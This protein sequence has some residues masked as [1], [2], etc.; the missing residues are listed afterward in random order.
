M[1]PTVQFGGGRSGGKTAKQ[2]EAIKAALRA[3][4]AVA[5]GGTDGRAVELALDAAGEIIEKSRPPVDPSLWRLDAS[6]GQFVNVADPTKR[7]AAFDDELYCET[8]LPDLTRT[9]PFPPDCKTSN[10]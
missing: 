9:T 7:V 3:G 10:S 2:N 1:T 8:S 6:R 4:Q 5:R